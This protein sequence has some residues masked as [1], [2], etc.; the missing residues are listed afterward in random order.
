MISRGGVRTGGDAL[1]RI[2]AGADLVQIY[3]PVLVE[4]PAAVGRMLGEM[5]E[6]M[7]K[8]ERES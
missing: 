2:K 1:E 5:Q 8:G 4:G 7:I 3:T 6:E